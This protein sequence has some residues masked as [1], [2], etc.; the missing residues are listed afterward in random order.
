MAHHRNR[1]L[2][3]RRPKPGGLSH[4]IYYFGED[5]LGDMQFTD[6]S[7]RLVSTLK[8]SNIS[9]LRQALADSE[10]QKESLKPLVDKAQKPPN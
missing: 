10:A 8:V 5:Y 7:N 9:L 1:V 4:A 3:I 2:M 6:K